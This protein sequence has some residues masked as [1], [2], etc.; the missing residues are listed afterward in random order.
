MNDPFGGQHA[1]DFPLWTNSLPERDASDVKG[2]SAIKRVKDIRSRSSSLHGS[3]MKELPA[4]KDMQ[5]LFGPLGGS[6]H[7][8]SCQGRGMQMGAD[9]LARKGFQLLR[10]GKVA[11]A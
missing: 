5:A 4:M 8:A 6:G 1:N 2:I 11:S 3:A 7:R 10:T 9:A